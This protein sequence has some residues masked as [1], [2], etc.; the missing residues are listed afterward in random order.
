MT[1]PARFVKT[2]DNEIDQFISNQRNKNTIR[3]TESDVKL[4]KQFIFDTTGNNLELESI[5]PKEL[6]EFLS[7]FIVSVRKVDGGEFEP[8][9]L[10]SI[11]S[12]ADRHLKAHS[13][14]TSIMEGACFERTK[15]AL[16]AKQKYLKQMGK[17]VKS[18]AAEPITDIDID[19]LWKNKQLGSASPTSV[20]NTLWLYTTMGFGL[21]GAQEHRSMCWGDV[22]L[23]E[24]Q[25][26]HEFLSFNERQTKT[27][28]GD[29]TDIRKI[30]PKLWANREDRSRCPIEIYKL[31]STKRPCDFNNEGDPFYIQTNSVFKGTGCETWFKR[32]PIG[33]NKLR[34]IM[35][36]MAVT[37][38]NKNI[39]LTN[40][41][42][43]KGLL[44]K[45]VDKNVPPTDIIQISGHKNV[46]SILNYSH[47]SNETH[48][49][50]SNI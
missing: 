42:A 7:N 6:N 35:K 27:R 5:P 1:M 29:T 2:T 22:S 25:E 31:Y 49:Q 8:S 18:N 11:I 21:R 26:G 13:Y 43:R 4:I 46:Q 44:Q 15:Q 20:I 33:E 47:I 34:N 30:T 37:L 48:K 45:F 9:T 41:S 50:M 23:Q 38:P 12:S 40:H 19:L 39:K 24:D 3:K 10:R 32:Q 17:G 16:K 14:G 36:K 28:Q